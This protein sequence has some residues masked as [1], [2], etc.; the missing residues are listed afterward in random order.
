VRGGKRYFAVLKLGSDTSDGKFDDLMKAEF[1]K[2]V[3]GGGAATSNPS[4]KT[5]APSRPP[6]LPSLD[7]K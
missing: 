6:A 1:I 3:C 5:G 2:L 4:P 7:P